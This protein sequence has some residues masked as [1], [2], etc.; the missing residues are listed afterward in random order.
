MK[1]KPCPFCGREPSPQGIQHYPA[2][3]LFNAKLPVGVTGAAWNNR[4]DPVKD[5]M[6][7]A[8]IIYRNDI[9]EEIE[10]EA[11]IYIDDIIE[12]ALGK[13]YEELNE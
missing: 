8:L 13:K 12:K 6:L 9:S 4:V 3:Y 7:N 1:L 10:D 2:C 11:G 5:E